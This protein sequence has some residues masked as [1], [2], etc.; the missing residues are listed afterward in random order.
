MHIII[1]NSLFFHSD[2]EPSHECSEAGLLLRLS[3]KPMKRRGE[4]RTHI[5]QELWLP[6]FSYT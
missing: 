5:E 4:F 3:S 6:R 1:G 2:T